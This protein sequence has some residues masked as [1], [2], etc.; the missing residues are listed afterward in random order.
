MSFV[1]G[2]DEL[3][4]DERTYDEDDAWEDLPDPR[5]QDERSWVEP[6]IEWW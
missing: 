5:R 2:D 6:E 3:G 4:Y 1:D